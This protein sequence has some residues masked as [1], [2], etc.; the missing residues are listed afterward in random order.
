M[1]DILNNTQTVPKMH[2]GVS[3]RKSRLFSLERSVKDRSRHALY[4]FFDRFGKMK[5]IIFILLVQMYAAA[6]ELQKHRLL[7]STVVFHV[8]AID[9]RNED[10]DGPFETTDLCSSC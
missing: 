10:G 4:N 1:S 9:G 2:P 6:I 8:D 5:V 7:A 3:L